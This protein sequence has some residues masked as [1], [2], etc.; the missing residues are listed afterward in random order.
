M[1]RQA[2]HTELLNG[3]RRALRSPHNR[4]LLTGAAGSVGRVAQLA[5]V[6]PTDLG[7]GSCGR[8]EGSVFVLGLC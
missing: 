2:V 1:L 3:S 7:V 4:R 6:G 8:G 5:A